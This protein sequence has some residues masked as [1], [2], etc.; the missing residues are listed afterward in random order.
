MRAVTI[1]LQLQQELVQRVGLKDSAGKLVA[2]VSESAIVAH[3]IQHRKGDISGKKFT[4]LSTWRLLA[5]P[6][7]VPHVPEDVKVQPKNKTR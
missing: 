3:I 1:T 4:D 6:N 5:K 2:Y 7:S